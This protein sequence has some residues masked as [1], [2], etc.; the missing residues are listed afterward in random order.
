MRRLATVLATVAAA[1]A[2]PAGTTYGSIRLSYDAAT[3]RHCDWRDEVRDVDDGGSSLHA[4]PV[5]VFAA[6]HCIR[7]FGQVSDVPPIATGGSGTGGV[8]CG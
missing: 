8:H 5:S 6:G 2:A 1:P 7:V 4:G 3:G